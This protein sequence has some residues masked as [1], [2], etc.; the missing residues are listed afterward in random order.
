VVSPLLPWF[1]AAP[2]AV[3]ADAAAEA[4]PEPA[5]AAVLA[6]VTFDVVE[7]VG[8]GAGDKVA[9]VWALMPRLTAPIV[10]P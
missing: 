5:R 2:F 3:L 1:A 10:V 9:I 7:V 4:R 6:A 8:V